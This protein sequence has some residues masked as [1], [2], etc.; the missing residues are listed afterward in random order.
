MTE[1]LEPRRPQ[2]ELVAWPRPIPIETTDR[3]FG[4]EDAVG[5]LRRRGWLIV[6]CSLIG[7]MTSGFFATRIAPSYEAAA[8]LRIDDRE[9]ELPGVYKSLSAGSEVETEAEVLRG[10]VLAEDAVDSLALQLRVLEPT[11]I[12]RSRLFTSIRVAAE[13][14]GAV[15]E[16]HR[17]ADG[18]YAVRDRDSDRALGWVRPGDTVRVPGAVFRMELASAA[19]MSLVAEVRGHAS[20]IEGTASALTVSR[21]SRDARIL[22]VQ[23]R[24]T[25]PQIVSQV[26]NLV[27]ARFILRR[28][29][30]QRDQAR[31]TV[32]FL[33]GQIDTVAAQLRIAEDSLRGYREQNRVVDP[34][35]EA[36][37]Q[38]SRL[39][40][41]QA[42]RTTLDAERAALA[43]LLDQVDAKA[44]VQRAGEPSPYRQL[45]AFPTLL[46]SRAATEVLQALS[47]VEQER[48]TL[49][50]RRLP[51]DADV[52]ELTARVGQ[53]QTELRGVVVT[54]LQ[55]LTNQVASLDAGL[56]GY[57]AELGAMPR[58]ELQV[59]RL[60]RK[61]KLLE[62]LSSIL[63]TR[64]K[65]AEIAQA[66]HDRSVTLVDPAVPPR[67]PVKSRKLA[68]LVAGL[69][70]GLMVG[71]ASSA[72]KEV[73]DKTVH[74]RAHLQ[75]ATGFPVLGL[76]PRIPQRD[77]SKLALIAERLPRHMAMAML[78]RG[79]SKAAY[80]PL[81][82]FL[83]NGSSE[84]PD[85]RDSAATALARSTD[86][87]QLTVSDMGSAI[88]EAYG[89]LQTNIEFSRL[90]REVKILLVTSA[91]PG[92]GKTTSAINLALTLA[93]RDLKVLLVDAD[94]RRGMVY[95]ALGAPLHPGLSEILEGK[96][97]FEDCTR[98]VMVGRG[99]TLTYL[100]A[101]RLGGNPSGLLTS[102]RMRR[103]LELTAQGY[104]TIVV[105]SPPV[106]VVTDAAVLSTLA[107]G[108]I[109]IAR[110]GVS[111][112][113]A[114]AYALEQLQH[115]KAPLLGVVLNDVDPK[116]DAAYGG[117]YRY[118]D[119]RQYATSSAG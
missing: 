87:T 46:Q 34:Q 58:K 74:T 64:L 71:L 61:P 72:L 11:A 43:K 26:P 100:T 4:W 27:V 102:Y 51:T 28:Q 113:G 88:A 69:I 24:D 117:T 114:L 1:S 109:L 54:Y 93:G 6:L 10:R 62:E 85:A 17:V 75:T 108:V 59:A 86:E 60:E 32:E 23:Y 97:T 112:P 98:S 104:D 31:T 77:R 81:Y 83:S 39:M 63:Q 118:H 80:R 65:E 44:K 115:V 49:L 92:E 56:A 45:M 79:G 14:E 9:P 37:G 68:L 116:R 36:S 53:L 70:G 94:L 3:E 48:S 16:F 55:S 30:G 41:L 91:L 50:A 21:P 76:I 8:T 13:A 89:I 110:A 15:Y 7:L 20:A 19:F 96:A 42:Q 105:D 106:N 2:P 66:A 18:R 22:R 78:N 67:Y 25:D 35:A 40:S 111:E 103:L 52:K 12:P 95:S 82:T 90:N 5:V 57:Q 47:T 29:A 99:R 73:R 38:M 107:D 84:A 119:Y 33:Q 101:G